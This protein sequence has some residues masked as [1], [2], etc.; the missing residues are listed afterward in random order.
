MILKW[1]YG[2][3]KENQLVIDTKK[4]DVIC[5]CSIYSLVLPLHTVG[6]VV[7]P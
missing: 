4:N 7:T 2:M 1:Y 5:A 6:A 3:Y